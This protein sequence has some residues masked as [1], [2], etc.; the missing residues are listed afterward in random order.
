MLPIMMARNGEM[1][2]V[3]RIGGRPEVKQHLMDLGFVLGTP[4][5]VIQSQNGAMIVKVKDSKL[6]ITKEMA[7]KI[8]VD[9]MSAAIPQGAGTQVAQA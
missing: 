4:V 2:R 1:L 8:M 9:T 3:S 5:T 6:A 7:E